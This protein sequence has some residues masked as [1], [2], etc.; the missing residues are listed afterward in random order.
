MGADS[1][2]KGGTEH[3]ATILESRQR[4]E[5]VR[6]CKRKAV[7]EQDFDLA[8]KLRKHELELAEGLDQREA[9]AKHCAAKAALGLL[10][11]AGPGGLTLVCEAKVAG[12][13][14]GCTK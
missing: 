4:L 10:E 3:G 9:T 2:P 1:T 5:R 13:I 14:A 11:S 6:S 8:S 12:I 7:E